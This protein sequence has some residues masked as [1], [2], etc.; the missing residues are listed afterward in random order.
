[1]IPLTNYSLSLESSLLSCKTVWVEL[2]HI[3]WYQN[4]AS[5]YDRGVT[6][7]LQKEVSQLQKDVV[8]IESKID[9]VADQIIAEIKLEL[10]RGMINVQKELEKMFVGMLS[11]VTNVTIGKSIQVMTETGSPTDNQ[12]SASGSTAM[13][14]T[15]KEA[16]VMDLKVSN[17]SGDTAKINPRVWFYGMED[18]GWNFFEAVNIAE[19]SQVQT[20]MIH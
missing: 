19:E 10:E 11:K 14:T 6:T 7:Q 17:S 5:W 2:I 16:M 9:G 15:G 12:K 4:G 8:K 20:D 1:M 18:Q 13:I 3:I